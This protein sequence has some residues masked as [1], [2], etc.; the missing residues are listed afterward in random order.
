MEVGGGLGTLRTWKLAVGEVG[1]WH[2]HGRTCHV[3]GMVHCIRAHCHD[4]RTRPTTKV[5]RGAGGGQVLLS[6]LCGTHLVRDLDEKAGV[7]RTCD[8]EVEGSVAVASF[9]SRA[10]DQLHMDQQSPRRPL[11][12]D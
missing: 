2:N 5:A 7:L 12:T 8:L 6:N 4:G 1:V 10:E 11:E 3:P 9:Y